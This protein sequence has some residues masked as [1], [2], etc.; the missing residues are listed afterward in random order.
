MCQRFSENIGKKVLSS[1]QIM[2][3]QN[4]ALEILGLYSLQKLK[5]NRKA[6]NLKPGFKIVRT[7]QLSIKR[8]IFR[9]IKRNKFSHCLSVG[10]M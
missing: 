5:L 2:M 7:W 10:A 3:A 1:V 6:L 9:Q 4:S 8:S